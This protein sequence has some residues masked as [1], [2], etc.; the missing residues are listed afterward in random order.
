MAT[1]K[2]QTSENSGT[3]LMFS[4]EDSPASL[5]VQQV[6]ERVKK[7]IDTSGRKCVEQYTRLNRATLS[8]KMFAALLIGTREWYSTRCNLTWKLRGTKSGRFYFQLQVLALP[9]KDTEFGLL[10]TPLVMDTN[11][12]DLA[13]VDARR[14][15]AKA[16]KING[17]GFGLTLGEL[18]KRGLLPTPQAIDGSGKG[19]PLR[20]KKDCNRDPNQPGSWRGDLKDHAVMGL[21]PTP[22][23][24]NYKGASSTEALEKRGRLKEKSDNLVDQFAVSGSTSQLNPRF[25]LE[26]MGFPPN[27]LDNEFEKIVWELYLKKK[28][29]KSFQK[30]LTNG[31][32]KQ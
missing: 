26:M 29:T 8:G 11:S 12:G 5:T 6:K 23:T 9:T 25:V 13:K 20:L 10:P 31:A 3:E 30:R 7:M 24:S 4:W 32:L 17:N 15:K 22:A 2:N 28:S 16:S 1:L 27:Y 14:E 19:R 21:L 18:G